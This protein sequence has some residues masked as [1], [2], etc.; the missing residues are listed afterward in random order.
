MEQKRTTAVGVFEDRSHAHFAIEELQRNGFTAEQIGVVVPDEG[1][2]ELPHLGPE[3]KA[4]EGAVVGATAG[5]AVGG[6]VGA[7]LATVVIP[8]V[9][10]VIA[11]GLLAAALGGAAAG[12]ASGTILGALIG[13]EIPEEEAKHYERKFHSGW[14]LVT[15][16]AEGR[17]DEAAAILKRAAER[18]EAQV[19]GHGR[20]RGYGSEE[21]S[22]SDG[23]G[24]VFTPGP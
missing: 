4:K 18:P 13:L 22:D 9:G 15:V 12:A 23:G 17:Y 5:V 24:S 2:I 3:T 1:K 11:A 19:P 20:G 6:L 7:A 10:P 8:G 14:T 16:K 21:G